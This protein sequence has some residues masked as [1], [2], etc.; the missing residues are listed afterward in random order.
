MIGPA[1]TYRPISSP[2]DE[3]PKTGVRIT[4][5]RLPD[6]PQVLDLAQKAHQI[7]SECVFIGWDI[8]LTPDGPLL[9]EGNVGWDVEMVQKPQNTPLSQTEFVEIVF[10]HWKNQ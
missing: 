6:W 9:V 2:H 4:G 8:A 5:R 3:H 1:D 10:A 7:F